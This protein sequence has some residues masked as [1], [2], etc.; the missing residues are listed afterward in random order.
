[1]MIS[2]GKIAYDGSFNGLRKITGNL[3]RFTVTTESSSVPALDGGHLI[4]AKNGVY[5]FEVDVTKKSY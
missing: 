4:S 2:N 1:M 3:T 5:E